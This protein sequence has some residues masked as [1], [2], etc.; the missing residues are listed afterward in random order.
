MPL[1]GSVMQDKQI[2]AVLF[3]LGETLIQFG[4]V[5]T[6]ELFRQGAK[7]THHYL[8]GL[9]QPVGGYGYYYLRNLI[10]LR[11]HHLLSNITGRDFDVLQLSK[12]VGAK[13]GIKLSDEQWRRF[14]WLWY[15]PLSETARTEAG[16]AETLNTLKNLGL[17]LGIL[18]NTFVNSASLEEHLRR[19]GILHFF[20]VRLYSYEFDF[21]KPNMAIFDI[22]A[23]RI[24]EALENIMFVGD[25]IDNDIRP[26]MKI[27][28]CAVL[29]AAYTNSGQQTPKGALRIKYLSELPPLIRKI[30]AT[31]RPGQIQADVRSSSLHRNPI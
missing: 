16:T 9:G 26:A 11:W 22:A 19:L 12:K 1:F 4:R 28:M 30:N 10:S 17:K 5:N 29:K 7:R 31:G 14:A 13:K 25:R 2:K 3:D 21:R 20:P 27:G 23:K 24:G 8:K 18:S 15:E 6:T